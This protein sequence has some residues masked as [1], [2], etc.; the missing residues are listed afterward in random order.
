M[1][2]SPVLQ[3]LKKFFAPEDWPWTLLALQQEHPI[4]T[5]LLAGTGSPSAIEGAVEAPH[6]APAGLAQRAMQALSSDPRRWTPAALGLL[7]LGVPAQAA[8]PDATRPT[9][10]L[11]RSQAAWET[12]KAA[13]QPRSLS[14]ETCALLALA[15]TERLR[16]GETLETLLADLNLDA[17]EAPALLAC[18]LTCLPQ[19]EDQQALLAALLAPSIGNPARPELAWRAF[20][21]RPLPEAEQ[22]T[23]LTA[24]VQ[25]LPLP[26][27]LASLQALAL[28]RPAL[29]ARLAEACLASG[30][31]QSDL[32]NVE[33]GD[34]DSPTN[35]ALLDGVGADPAMAFDRLAGA[36]RH[37]QA[38]R[39]A[40]RPD[41]AVTLLAEA[42]R[43]LRRQRGHLS[44][45]LAQA[46][47]LTHAA[48]DAVPGAA[49]WRDAAQETSLEAWKQAVQLAPERP[50]YA[51]GWIGALAA[52]GRLEEAQAALAHHVG[53]MDACASLA[54]TAARLAAACGEQ[55]EAARRRAQALRLVQAGQLLSEDQFCELAEGLRGADKSAQ[56]A[57]EAAVAAI[58]AGLRSFPTSA[59]LW[60]L[61]APEQLA[62]GRPDDALHAA[63]MALA[64][65]PPGSTAQTAA[66]EEIILAALEALSAWDQALAM[67]L[68]RLE[69]VV[70]PTLEELQGLR[71]C[72][73]GAG[74]PDTL[75]AAC[76]GILEIDPED[77]D[78]LHCLAEAAQAR[79]DYPAAAERLAQVVRLAPDRPE[80]W[81][82]LVGAYRQAGQAIQSVDAL[83]A[84]C[85]ALPNYAEAHLQ[86]G[87]VYAAQNQPTQA[88]ACFR[89]AARI[90]RS[91]E[92]LARL[93]RTL[94]EVG[95][96]EEAAETLGPAVEAAAGDARSAEL[97][98]TYARALLGIQRRE[99]AIPL[100]V[101]VTRRDPAQLGPMM[102]LARAFMQ[103]P[104]QP[105]GARRALPFL[106]RI[107]GVNPDGS[108]GGYTGRLEAQP[109][110]RGEARAL[111]AEAYAAVSDHVAAMQAFRAALDDPQNA[112][113]EAR[114]RLS[115]GL[116][117]AALKLEQPELAV[118]ALQEA[119]A[120]GPLEP[121]LQRSLSEA[122][123]ASGLVQDAFQAAGQALEMQPESADN[124]HWFIEQAGRLAA[125]PEAAQLPLRPQL[126][127]ALEAAARLEPQ[128]TEWLVRLGLLRVESGDRSGALDA[129]RRLAA[130]EFSTELPAADALA[131]ARSARELGDPGLSAR[132]LETALHR[133][134]PPA[135][136]TADAAPQAAAPTG[137]PQADA[138]LASLYAELSFARQQAADLPGALAAAEQALDLEP[139][140]AA[141]RVRHADLLYS[142][143]RPDEALESLVH[144][145][146]LDPDDPELR[147][148]AAGWMRQRGRLSE[149]L[150]M[151]ERG[152]DALDR[153]AAQD[154]DEGMRRSL[155]LLAATVSLGTLRPLRAQAY[156]KAALSDDDPAGQEYA[157]A[158]LRAEIALEL[159]D[160]D[161]ARPAVESMQRQA[162]NRPRTE[163]ARARLAHRAG[164][165]RERERRCRSAA[166]N[167]LRQQ[168]NQPAAP[169]SSREEVAAEFLSVA[170]A[171]IDSRLWDEA[172]ATLNR[173]IEII[174]ETPLAYFKLAQIAILRA[175][176]QCL[177]AEFEVTHHAEGA[178]VLAEAARQEAETNLA[179][180]QSMLGVKFDLDRSADY[181]KWNDECLLALGGWTARFLSVFRPDV[182]SARV[183]ESLLRA[184]TP[185]AEDVAAL[186]LAYRRCS[187]RTLAMSAAQVAWKPA[188]DGRDPLGR[189][190]ILVQMALA[191]TDPAQ[192]LAYASKALEAALASG[193][194][195]P[196]L[197]AIEF[198][199]A[200]QAF[201]MQ[202]YPAALQAIQQALSAWPDEPRWQQLAAR[203]YQVSAPSAG[204]PDPVKALLHYEQAVAQAPDN[205]DNYVQVG[206]IYLSG[207]QV[208]RAVQALERAVA[209]DQKRVDAWLALAQA[210]ARLGNLEAAAVSADRAAEMS[211]A[212]ETDAPPT[213]P[214]ESA[215]LRSEALLLR[216]QLS[217][218][219]GNPRGALSRAQTLLRIQP[220]HPEAL[221][222]LARAL[223]ALNRPADALQ[224]LEKALPLSRSPLAMQIER[225]E[226]V[227]RTQGL[228]AAIAALQAVVDQPAPDAPDAAGLLGEAHEMHQSP[229]LLALL[230]AWLNEA[231]QSDAAIQTARAALA[232]PNGGLS[233]ERRAEMNL[234]IGLQMRRAG[235]LDQAILRL[236]EAVSYAP[237]SVD[238]YLELGRAY[239]ERR[240]YR[241][242]LKIYQKAMGVAADDYRPYYHAGL[243]LKDS[244]DYI[245]AEA[246]LR[247][248][249]QIAPDEVSV[250]RLL[251]AVVALNLVHNRKVTPA[252]S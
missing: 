208:D 193:V 176:A 1:T 161:L 111:L 87:D 238:A 106:L 74:Q 17:P 163:A 47:D 64:L 148:R 181:K 103:L 122:Y 62:L 3:S 187:E 164:D 160:A 2:N 215:Q 110:L 184:T 83:R 32:T 243:V 77:V 10:L 185:A 60:A 79:G 223:E 115:A 22:A 53:D 234:L 230:A 30:C 15:L 210:Q 191:E 156:L 135:A 141:R 218:Q 132:L 150:E 162:P 101:E 144:A 173:L 134:E 114:S 95:H 146:E 102:D 236:S 180:A 169:P 207:G 118:A 133:A 216:G 36:L 229:E 56:A 137:A 84:A 27:R 90:E 54:L 75:E 78:A 179:R 45:A 120:A 124:L 125:C 158:A 20:L 142:L 52:A 116:G 189:P 165:E 143:N 213:A 140:V 136:E 21:C 19:P 11:R 183:Y 167:L 182:Q 119:A 113:P 42:L 49:N 199:I 151:A 14:L 67:R 145:V 66:L 88:L 226:L 131:V 168:I 94:L 96:A 147:R 157:Y 128:R 105:G 155:N 172:V 212:S 221:Y 244:K 177:Y 237:A 6:A 112:R 70:D 7:A 217:L 123:L 12:Y 44:A 73:R 170:Q 175:E 211:P 41:R 80:L 63:H 219:T 240:E 29:A 248:A 89:R 149:A 166:R 28:R 8:E 23:I 188:F 59:R 228:N 190:L 203:L 4:W 246:M 201:Q 224:A 48:G 121:G 26:A 227:R 97:V 18:L 153:R 178:V 69:G 104:A 195:W 38:F 46:L 204:L 24:W 138:Q 152:L 71:R 33:A 57:R 250:H 61:L 235:H 242:A 129:Y 40:G 247:R 39:L 92:L 205:V 139:E 25:A 50:A 186:M 58:Q 98:Y 154:D 65:L 16:Q 35:P 251:G 51:A 225:V 233:A 196:P 13:G 86:L 76:H 127:R 99:Q 117:M 232:D 249:A 214:D 43:T 109:Q 91:P 34:E 126:G 93:G 198:L 81:M 85:Q 194:A 82:A 5:A 108:P 68:T 31:E 192:A 209:L 197:P 55:P 200:R 241:Q 174:P 107:L 100:L 9:D 220:D 202:S 231:G 239:Q 159:G 72:A 222:L 245:A 37:A 130:S 252:E 171:A 206:K